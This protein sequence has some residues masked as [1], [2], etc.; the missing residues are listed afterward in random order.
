MGMHI[1]LEYLFCLVLC[2]V[3]YQYQIWY[4]VLVMVSLF[5]NTILNTGCTFITDGSS[6][7]AALYL[8]ICSTL[9]GSMYYIQSFP[10]LSFS[11]RCF[12]D[13]RTF[14]LDPM[15]DSPHTLWAHY[16]S[17]S[18]YFMSSSCIS[19]YNFYKLDR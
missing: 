16:L 19:V 2:I 13:N 7:L 10:G 8:I 4:Y 6:N 17:T 1:M 15:L 9:N 18:A 3:F 11:F 14:S 12:V 5:S